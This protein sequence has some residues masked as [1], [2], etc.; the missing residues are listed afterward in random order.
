VLSDHLQQKS[1]LPTDAV[2]AVDAAALVGCDEAQFVWRNDDGG[3]TFRYGDDGRYL[4]WVPHDQCSRLDDAS[5]RSAWASAYIRV[6]QFT[7]VHPGLGGWW[8]TSAAIPGDSAVSDWGL[9]HPE[10]S[11]IAMATGLRR[12]HDGTPVHD[13]PFT[14]DMADQVRRAHRRIETDDWQDA[15]DDYLASW[16]ADDARAILAEGV[17]LAQDLVVCHGD[18]C[19]PNTIVEHGEFSGLVDIADLGVADRWAD[20]AVATWSLGWNF[21]PGWD[22]IFYAAYETTPDETKIR[23]YRLLWNAGW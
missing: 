9:A 19:A 6:P 11:V 17:N 2:S 7:P 21:G 10:Q 14:R 8:T 15:P 22:D 12:L 5:R 3:F 16:S 1:P 4:T 20:L 18:S 13:C 23:F